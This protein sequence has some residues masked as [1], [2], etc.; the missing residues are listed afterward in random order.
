VELAGHHNEDL[1]DNDSKYGKGSGFNVHER[2]ASR[3]P[4]VHWAQIAFHGAFKNPSFERR[5]ACAMA[6]PR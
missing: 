4:I 5:I 2:T 1:V 3:R 6:M